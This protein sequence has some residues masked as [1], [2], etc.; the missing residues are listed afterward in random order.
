MPAKKAARQAVKRSARNRSV[1]TAT[2]TSLGAAARSIDSGDAD[3]A[4]RALLAAISSLDQ[5][6]RKGVLHKNSASRRKSRLTIKFNRLLSGETPPG[7]VVSPSS[8]QGQRA[9]SARR[10]NRRRSR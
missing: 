3:E 2:R 9:S 4:E 7:E 10:Q 1:R 6:V 5:A 8:R